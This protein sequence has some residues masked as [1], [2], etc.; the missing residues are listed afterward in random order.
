MHERFAWHVCEFD[1][2]DKFRKVRIR[3]QTLQESLAKIDVLVE[4]EESVLN[5]E[6]V[7]VFQ[8]QLE[9]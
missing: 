9:D 8:G 1:A 6:I 4:N 3:R 5:G 7:R 2:R